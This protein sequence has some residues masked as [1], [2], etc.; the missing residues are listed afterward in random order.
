[1]VMIISQQELDYLKAQTA[2]AE[3]FKVTKKP[4][5]VSVNLCEIDGEPVVHIA[6][7]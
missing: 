2:A 4:W 7:F 3:H 6:D 5:L 1:M